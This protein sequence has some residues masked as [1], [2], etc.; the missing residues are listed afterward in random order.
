MDGNAVLDALQ[1]SALAHAISQSDHLVGA[2]LQILHI[3]GFLLLLTALLLVTL[4]AWNKVLPDVPL[5][6][7]RREARRLAIVGFL[8]AALSGTLVFIATPRL[9]VGN[10]AFL[11]KMALL[12]AAL[13]LHWMLVRPL[14]DR[15]ETL[16]LPG[17]TIIALSLLLWFGVSIAGRVIGFI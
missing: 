2:G 12:A 14:L 11:L 5:L 8:L 6:R 7:V 13:L 1:G 17:Q 4:R 15:E 9:Y 16:R 10:R 3:L